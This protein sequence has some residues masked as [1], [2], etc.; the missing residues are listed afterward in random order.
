[1]LQF[2]PDIWSLESVRYVA[3][4][5]F[6]FILAVLAQRIGVYLDDSKLRRAVREGLTQELAYNLSV[7]DQYLETLRNNVLETQRAWPLATLE[8]G[9]LEHCHDPAVAAVLTEIERVQSSIAYHQCCTLADI[10]T[11]AHAEIREHPEQTLVTCRNIVDTKL[12]VVGQTLID[13]LCNVL[14][15]HRVFAS[16][17]S[18]AIAKNLMPLYEAN[19]LSSDR[20]WRTS[21]VPDSQWRGPF[22]IAWRNDAP[23]RVPNNI[24][25]IELVPPDV[26]YRTINLHERSWHYRL[27]LPLAR[28]WQRAQFKR[29]VKHSGELE[30]RKAPIRRP[31]EVSSD[32]G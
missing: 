8:T 17:E 11:R 13:L 28:K 16:T 32:E 20:T 10:M 25:V 7:L 31:S 22:Y 29:A 9:I 19:A 21:T 27:M 26:P 12:P 23:T 15:A 5:A 6:G 2:F 14:S 1:M 24:Q 18:A 4:T 30:P 3:A